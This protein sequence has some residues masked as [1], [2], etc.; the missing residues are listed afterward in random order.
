MTGLNDAFIISKEKRNE[1]IKA[2][3]KSADII[4]P[5]LRGRDIKRYEVN[6]QE[7]Y[8]IALFP[9]RKYDIEN[10]PA[11][12]E[13][14][15]NGDWVTIKTKGNPPTPIGSGRLRLE[16]SSKSYVFEGVKFKTRKKTS[17]KWFETQD[18]IGYW[19][20]FSN[21]KIIY[22][23][24]T[25][26]LP[27]FL[28]ESNFLTNQK[29]FIVTGERLGSLAAFCNSSL[30]KFAYSDNFPELQ[31]GTRE[32]SKIFFEKLIVKKVD[33]R[34]EESYLKLINKIQDF[35]KQ[36]RDTTQLEHTLDMKIYNE[37]QLNSNE[38][39]EIMLTLK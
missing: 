7:Q 23:N 14:L 18:S 33:K 11:I 16:Q 10:Y 29:A 5:I 6:F 21:L 31:G 1:L 24:M 27:F 4:R 35:K 26:F 34:S 38:I 19:N 28:D 17:N 36:N 39:N 22:P 30:F 13:W 9:S 32:L 12:K 2:D 37:Y 20:D 8:I 15:I 25:K 3:P